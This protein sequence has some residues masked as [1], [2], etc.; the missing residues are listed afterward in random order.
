MIKMPRLTV[1]TILETS[2]NQMSLILT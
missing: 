1:P 2:N